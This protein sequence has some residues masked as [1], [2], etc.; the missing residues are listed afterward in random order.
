MNCRFCKSVSVFQILDLGHSPISNNFLSVEAL[1]NPE[2]TFPLR[3][4]FCKECF[5]V[6][7]VDFHREEE[8]FDANYPYFSSTSESWVQHA[9][10]FSRIAI[11]DLGL[12]EDSFVIEVAS[13]DGYLLQHFQRANIP[14]LGVEPTESTANAAIQKGIPTKIDFLNRMSAGS[15]TSEF[16]KADLVIG[17]NVFAHVPDILGFTESLHLLLNDQG[18]LVLEFPHVLRM[19][20]E[21]TFDTI[22]H[23]HF[24]YLSLLSVAKIFDKSNLKIWKIENLETHGGSLRV[25]G[26][27]KDLIRPIDKSVD[28][29]I[30]EELQFQLN[31]IQPYLTLQSKALAVKF[32][33]SAL[34]YKL[35]STGFTLAAAGAAAKGNTLLNYLG[36]DKDTISFAL[37]SAPSKQGKYTPGSHIPIFEFQYLETMEV[38]YILI[39]PW[40]IEKEIKKLCNSFSK[41]PVQFISI[42]DILEEM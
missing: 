27:K 9:E 11:N 13:N 31:T 7:T 36:I 26:C 39:L 24:S 32:Q 20:Q 33:L 29:C 5:L 8:I 25:Y 3:L 18:A 4:L 10:E 38:D 2:P 37:D 17:N 12:N 41:T 42:M 16:G 1:E 28:E 40:N 34:I 30:A 23:E 15:I 6:Q 14:V 19:L 22:Y 35:K 21:G